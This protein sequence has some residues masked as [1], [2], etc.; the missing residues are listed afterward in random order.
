[1]KGFPLYTVVG[2]RLAL[3]AADGKERVKGSRRRLEE[4]AAARREFYMH[5]YDVTYGL[6]RPGSDNLVVIDDSIVRGNTMRNAILPILDRL[7]PKKIVIASSAPPLK[8]PD[9]YGIDMAS[10]KELVAFEAAVGLLKKYG[11]SEILDRC[12]QEAKEQQIGRAHV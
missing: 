8:Y 1:M 10:L 5:V 4:E 6:R 3:F 9:C 11:K 7:G 12:Y 2:D